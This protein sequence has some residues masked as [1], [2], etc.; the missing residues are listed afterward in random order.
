MYDLIEKLEL[1]RFATTT[2]GLILFALWQG[3]PHKPWYWVYVG[4]SEEKAVPLLDRFKDR[5]GEE[6]SRVVGGRSFEQ[7]AARSNKFFN[8]IPDQEKCPG[9]GNSS[10]F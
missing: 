3:K 5:K 7:I 4:E 9:L 8:V 6:H 2:S 1:E 10:R